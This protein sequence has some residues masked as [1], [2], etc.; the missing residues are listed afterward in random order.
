MPEASSGPSRRIQKPR[1]RALGVFL[2]F[3]ALG[4]KGTV[5]ADTGHERTVRESRLF[6]G[7]AWKRTGRRLTDDTSLVL[8]GAGLFSA[9]MTTAADFS[10][11]DQAAGHR[12]MGPDTEELGDF[13]GTGIPGV[14]I[15][16]GQYVFDVENADAHGRALIATSVLTHTLKFATGRR[17]P[18]TSPDRRSFPSG[19]TS[20]TF[21]TATSLTLAYGWKAGIVAYPLAV[22]SGA[23]RVSDDVHWASDVVAGAFLGVIV[24]RAAREQGND[25]TSAIWYPILEHDRAGMGV[26]KAF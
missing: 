26:T 20:T 24:A 1:V 7:E 21:A 12:W 8:A 4:G 22:L 14:L 9:A 5:A 23:S 18:G 3:L 6:S 19:H 15:V 2:F 16:T 25:P 13:L 17:R 10:L 11:R